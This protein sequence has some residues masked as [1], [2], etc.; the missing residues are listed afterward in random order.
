MAFFSYTSCAR[1]CVA[2]LSFAR[3]SGL[4]IHAPLLIAIGLL[5]ILPV[6]AQV[7]DTSFD[8]RLDTT[9]FN[10]KWVEKI[11]VLPDGKMIASGNFNKYNG[12]NVGGLIRVNPDGSL[13]TSFEND[14]IETPGVSSPDEL[15]LL[16]DGKILVLGT[17]PLADGTQISARMIRLNPDGTL[18]T[19][20]TYEPTGFG[21]RTS[22][23]SMGRV[24]VM[25]ALQYIRNGQPISTALVRL[26][27]NGT[28]D[29]SFNTSI[30]S[31]DG[32]TTQGNK[33]VYI[34]SETNGFVVR[35]LNEN[36]SPDASFMPT[37]IGG[38]WPSVI[39]EQ[40]DHKILLLRD[41]MVI[42]VNVDGG[43]DNTFQG[44]TW[45]TSSGP[46]MVVHSDNR[47]TIR[48]H[49]SSSPFGARFIRLLPNGASDPSFTSYL[50]PHE[51]SPA[52]DLHADG[53]IMIGDRG[54]NFTANTFVKLFS[55]GQVDTGYNAGQV[56]FQN[57]IPGKIRAIRVLP[58]NK[59]LIGGDFDRV[60]TT[61]RQKLALLNPNSTLDPTFQIPTTATGNYFSQI[62]DVYHIEPQ[63]DGKLLVSGDFRYFVGGI[64]KMNVVRLNADGSI[65]PSFVLG[66]QIPNL[67]P[68]SGQSTN[69]PLQ[70]ADGK[71][72]VGNTRSSDQSPEPQPPIQLMSNGARDTSFNPALYAGQT[73]IAYDLA[74]L[75]DGKILVIGQRSQ[76]VG[77]TIS[78]I[79]G[80]VARLNPDGSTDTTFQIY[81]QLDKR[82]VAGRVLPDGKILV[83]HRSSN[84]SRLYRVNADGTPDNTFNN[85]P[86]ANGRLNT[87]VVLEDGKILVGG[88]FTSFNGESRKN[89]VLLGPDGQVLPRV[90]NTNK[91]VFCLSLDN[92]GR[93][94]VGGS[95]TSL[96]GFSSSLVEGE[97]EFNV[98]Y[99]ARINIS[100]TG[101]V[102]APFDFDGD[103]KTDISIFRP[104]VAEWWITRSS[105]GSVVAGQ[106]GATTDMIMPGDFTGDGKTDVALWRPSSGEWFVLR[107]DD[108]SYFSFPFGTNGDVPVV[109][110]FDN[111]SKAD[112][113]I[114]RPSTFTW[115]IRRSG[116]G[117]TTIRQFGASGDVP[118]PADYDGDGKTDIAIYRPSLG[119][120]WIDRSTDGVLALTFGGPSD[121]PVQGDYTGDGKA[122][123]AIW[124][125]STGEWYVL[126]SENHSY[127]SVPFGVA[128][129]VVAPGDYD[130]DGKFDNA[131][132]RPSMGTWYV[133]RST[134]GTLITQFGAT[135]DR[136]MAN[137]F[138]P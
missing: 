66:L 133:A 31:M 88:L 35:R 103:G 79:N 11:L 96:S 106:F 87:L 114:Y 28:V 59:I 136:P 27:A 131:V 16:S 4:P 55:G 8:A 89:L 70:R 57:F 86:G 13:D 134:G 65:D 72:L 53:S 32:F 19:T 12:Q 119:Q 51:G 76:V 42:R 23:D 95:F 48:Y 116:D 90:V 128:S 126:R 67:F 123:V 80:F 77:P 82:F 117:G 25:G 127:Y 6:R 112:A 15:K 137:A 26:N 98:S 10:Q 61:P 132:F 68:P 34:K 54:P 121:K 41:T 124:R 9:T 81:E 108:G 56:G 105:N 60:N 62:T 5:S 24:Y 107:S 73:V 38:W 17:F 109:G 21:S 2:S 125:P 93:V 91:E 58:S 78:V 135:G 37:E 102:R 33:I 20:F 14:L 71:V 120:W 84:A 115:Y 75:P 63:N 40:S 52:W 18:D 30:T 118:V 1:R 39:D 122:D 100:V 74:I 3:F 85:G 83:I 129:D 64:Q 36:G 45:T 101:G 7:I 47:I 110:D 43:M 97:Q 130:G 46:K 104:S 69:R 29:D 113:T 44:P 22:I 111:D 92:D 49:Q 94:L 138:V 50:Y 99:L